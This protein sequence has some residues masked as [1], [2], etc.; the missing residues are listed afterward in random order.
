MS[1]AIILEEHHKDRKLHVQQ[2]PSWHQH[3]TID[4]TPTTSWVLR[5]NVKALLLLHAADIARKKFF[6]S[7]HNLDIGTKSQLACTLSCFFNWWHTGL[8]LIYIFVVCLFPCIIHM[9][10]FVEYMAIILLPGGQKDVP[11]SGEGI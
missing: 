8:W 6:V 5:R 3:S 4:T 1:K 9:F 7:S 10:Q 11:K 2:Q